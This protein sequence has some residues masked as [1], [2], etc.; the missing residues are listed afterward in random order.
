V[1]REKRM[2]RSDPEPCIACGQDTGPG[3]RRFSGR[4]LVRSVDTGEVVPVCLSCHAEAP[5]AP[6]SAL[7][8]VLGQ[9]GVIEELGVDPA[10]VG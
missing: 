1:N 2:M 3:T 7:R 6:G 5:R 4:R 9:Y 10:D 8:R